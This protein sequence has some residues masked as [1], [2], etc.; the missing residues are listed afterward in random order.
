MSPFPACLAGVFAKLDR[1]KQ[2]VTNLDDALRAFRQSGPPEVGE[3]DDPN[4]GEK[5]YYAKS[6]PTIPDAVHLIAGDAL[7]NLRAS[8]DHL[9]LQLRRAG[10][11]RTTTAETRI[12]FPIRASAQDCEADLNRE[13]QATRPDVTN[14][15]R[16][17]EPYQGGLGNDLWLLNELNN[18]DKHRTLLVIGGACLYI[19]L[20]T[21]S[22]GQVPPAFAGDYVP[23]TRCGTGTFFRSSRPVCPVQVGTPL[24]VCPA[25]AVPRREV[26][27]DFAVALGEPE[28]VKGQPLL[29]T[30]HELVEAVEGVIQQFVPLFS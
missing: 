22:G 27:F 14:L 3:Q 8:L 16:A 21:L 9:A 18:I 6:V 23:D 13:E 28:I 24:H 19:S 25:D 10:L 11:F 7:H 1:A 4:T 17:I 12:Q 30:I 15:I 26:H 5:I 2:H 29:R 20:G